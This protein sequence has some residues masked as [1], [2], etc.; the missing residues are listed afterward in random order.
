MEATTPP[1]FFWRIAFSA[2]RFRCKLWRIAG[3]AYAFRPELFSGIVRTPGRGCIMPHRISSYCLLLALLAFAATHAHAARDEVQFGSNIVVPLGYSV[4]DAVCFFCS[5]NAQGT[6]DH[7]V[8]VFFGK[9][10]IA[11][12]AN[13]DV[14]NFF[15]KVTADDN[16]SI[17]HDLVSF[18]G[19]VR[20]GEN[21]SVGQDL[22]AIFGRVHTANSVTIGNDRVVQPGWILWIPLLVV[23]LVIFL[24][25]RAV[26]AYRERQ[27]FNSYQV[28]PRQ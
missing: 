24:V 16:A 18:F 19:V 20:L 21:V 4:H 6:V 8:V 11:G 2:Y 13:H 10:H 25:I 26:R 3:P 28:P 23:G 14:V 9:I 12:H 7:D 22:V 5:V 1:L 15:G 17:G 27:L